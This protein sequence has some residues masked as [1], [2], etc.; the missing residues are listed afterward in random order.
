VDDGCS[1]LKNF[2]WSAEQETIYRGKLKDTGY[3]SVLFHVIRD[4]LDYYVTLSPDPSKKEFI[5]VFLDLFH[6]DKIA[7][8]S[9]ELVGHRNGKLLAA[10]RLIVETINRMQG[11]LQDENLRLKIESDLRTSREHF[12]TLYQCTTL[13]CMVSLGC[14]RIGRYTIIYTLDHRILEM[15]SSDMASTLLRRIYEFTPG[16]M[17]PFVR[18]HSLQGDCIASFKDFFALSENDDRHVLTKQELF[19]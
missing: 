3:D 18:F 15:L 13:F 14:D 6:N 11:W 12:S 9:E 8:R 1:P 5:G 7:A 19:R 10:Y 16:D 2:T 4:E 17:E